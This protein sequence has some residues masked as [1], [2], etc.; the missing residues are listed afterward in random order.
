MRRAH[1]LRL[2]VLATM[3][4]LF[5]WSTRAPPSSPDLAPPPPLAARA[6]PSP[7][8][9]P[10]DP[11][12]AGLYI[13]YRNPAAFLQTLRSYRAAYP[14][15]SLHLF[16]DDGAH[17]FGAAARHFNATF[18]G[19]AR[20]ITAKKKGS[21][22][23]GRPN[24]DVALGVVRA[25]L[26]GVTEP[27]LIL[28]EDDVIV[29]RRV[30]SPLLYDIQGCAWDH[31]TITG[32][33]EEFVRRRGGGGDNP[34]PLTGFGGSVFRARALRRAASPT[35]AE[36]DELYQH[37]EDGTLGTDYLFGALVAAANGTLGCFDGFVEAGWERARAEQLEREGRLE[38]AHGEKGAYGRALSAEDLAVLG[39]GWERALLAG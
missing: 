39:P 11:E 6:P 4:A 19:V 7:S 22:Y 35:A 23:F 16:A 30:R 36:L 8:P 31:K 17:N 10:S 32:Y 38:V 13:F 29:R 21:T 5:E 33:P 18:D 28:L 12:L 9:S 2:F 37:A 3:Y 24:A 15:A 27:F 25:A 26:S 1:R 20:R 14:T 34:L